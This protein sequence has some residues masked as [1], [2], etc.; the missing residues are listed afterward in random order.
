MSDFKI[1]MRLYEDEYNYNRNINNNNNVSNIIIMHYDF[2][3]TMSC[4]IEIKYKN[5][6][7][8]LDFIVF[9]AENICALG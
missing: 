2:D 3:N 4:V 7:I 1:Y 5:V 8:N 6:S 9:H